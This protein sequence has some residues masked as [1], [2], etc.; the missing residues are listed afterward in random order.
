MMSIF[1]PEPGMSESVVRSQPE[2]WIPLQAS[3]DEVDHQHVLVPPQDAAQDHG[4]VTRGWRSSL[5]ISTLQGGCGGWHK[6]VSRI[7]G[8]H[9]E[10][11]RG[12]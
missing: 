9:R 2:S 6:T 8:G 10:E 4:E 12:S 11:F 7:S 3:P 1:A 5:N